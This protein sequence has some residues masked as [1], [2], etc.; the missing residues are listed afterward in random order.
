MP[1]Y[2][3]IKQLQNGNYEVRIQVKNKHLS[4][5][6]IKRKDD[7]GQPFKTK[8]AAA[9]YRDAYIKS[10][11][12]PQQATVK[13]CTLEDVY[14]FYM[15]NGAY[16][17]A[18]STIRKQES[19][20]L[21]H[22]KP[23]FGDRSLSSFSSA[24]IN[25]YLK[26][27]YYQGD[28]YNP[29][30]NYSYK[31]VESFLKL[32]YLLFSTAY[33]ADFISVEK[34]GKLILDKNTKIKMPKIQQEDLEDEVQVF[35][36]I[37]LRDIETVFKRGN[38]YTAFLLGIY[39]GLRISEVFALTW[40]DYSI[41]NKQITVNKQLLYQDGVWCLCPV[42]T[43]TAVRV[44]DLPPALND[45]LHSN[46]SKFMEIQQKQKNGELLG[47]R[48][49]ERVIDKTKKPYVECVGLDFINRKDN[50][51]L[52]TP[53]SIKYWSKIIKKELYI[54]FHFHSL[55][56]TH[57]TMMANLNTPVLELMTRLGHKKYD[58]TLKYYINENVLAKDK[59]KSNLLEIQF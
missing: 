32:F 25:N 43:L 38:C 12:A 51:E 40:S 47:Y 3:G 49:Y 41:L 14:N 10:K 35:D 53:N 54:D 46:W 9:D 17:K 55:R 24:E 5:N 8:K 27:L 16:D 33:S 30:A 20:W 31:Y 11:Q 1:N 39:C 26:E 23:V 19:L 7:N 56:K 57:A 29:Q 37:D 45:Y 42:K 48:N 58:T 34:Y 59:L 36:K 6:T 28:K 50:G 4:I 52:L 15:N 44:I 22:I 2:S 21:N 13:D 18:P